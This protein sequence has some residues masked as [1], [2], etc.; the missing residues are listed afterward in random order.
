[1]RWP[2]NASPV[3]FQS[4]GVLA[5]EV[6]DEDV[7]AGRLCR[8]V[9]SASRWHADRN[10]RQEGEDQQ[11]EMEPGKGLFADRSGVVHLAFSG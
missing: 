3:V 8:L 2:W 11:A 7:V 10:H 1:M 4:P 5:L 6:G 9:C